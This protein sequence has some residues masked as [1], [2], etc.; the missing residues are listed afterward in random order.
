MLE[1][2]R[3]R[4][5]KY[6][7]GSRSRCPRC[8]YV[9]AT[10]IGRH[11]SFAMF[12]FQS[13][14]DD[15]RV[16]HPA[17]KGYYSTIVPALVTTTYRRFESNRAGIAGLAVNEVSTVNDIAQMESRNLAGELSANAA[18]LIGSPPRSSVAFPPHPTLPPPLLSVRASST[19]L[20]R[21][22]GRAFF[23]EII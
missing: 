11:R 15:H 12:I 6:F 14:R 20:A 8:D 9:C 18:K 19:L 23:D 10:E 17:V 13:C 3:K 4:D 1:R 7:E 16:D 5:G 21:F 2:E 22:N